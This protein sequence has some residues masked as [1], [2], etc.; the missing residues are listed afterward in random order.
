MPATYDRRGVS[1]QYPEN[2][3]VEEGQTDE[4]WCVTV[5]SAGTAF[6]LISIHND[7]PTVR[8]VLDTTLAALR[9]DYPDLEAEEA[10]EKLAGHRARGHDVRFFSLDMVNTCWLRSFRTADRTFL[11]LCQASDLDAD[12]AEPVLR[13]MR[14]T[15]AVEEEG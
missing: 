14:A 4:G 7:R 1:F 11:V 6:F 2:W 13:A 10:E 5:Q 12:T 9:E 15:L 3:A 8:D